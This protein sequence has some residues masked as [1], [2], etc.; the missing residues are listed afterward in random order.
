MRHRVKRKL[1][2]RDVDHRKALIR[3]MSMSLIMHESIKTTL[4]KAKYIKPR[5]EKLITKARK[6][7]DFTTI[8]L[9]EKELGSQSSTKEAIRKLV[10]DLGP[11]YANRSGGY[12]RIVKT[13]NRDG[14]NA[15]TARLELVKEKPA[16]EAKT[17]AEAKK[18]MEV[19][20]E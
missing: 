14:D 19:V 16:K 5:V 9:L 6:G 11:R 13:G 2:N 1:L 18:S 10:T 12:T 4:T 17:K 3:N 8:K 15:P 7:T 20:K